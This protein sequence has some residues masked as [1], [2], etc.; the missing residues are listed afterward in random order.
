[1]KDQSTVTVTYIIACRAMRRPTLVSR[2][3]KRQKHRPYIAKPTRVVSPIRQSTVVWQWTAGDGLFRLILR[4]VGTGA[5]T[6]GHEGLVSPHFLTRDAAMLARSWDRNYDRLSVCLSVCHTRAFWQKKRIYCR[7]FDTTWK[8]NQSS[9]LLPTKVSG[10]CFLPPE[11]WT[12][13]DPPTLK[14]AD[15]DQYLLNRNS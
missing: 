15:F 8:G 3:V 4:H 2:C 1:M 14:N 11:I 9:F 10:Q 6:V 7:Y 5:G 13:S 12:Q